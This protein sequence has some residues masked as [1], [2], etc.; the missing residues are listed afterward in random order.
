MAFCNRCGVEDGTSFW[1]GSRLVG[2]DGGL[3]VEAPLHEEAL[4]VGE[5]DPAVLR[6]R[7]QAF[8]AVRD[9]RPEVAFRGLERILRDRAAGGE[10][11]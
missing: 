10:A 7:R 6:R 5:L 9:E 1:G 11:P 8:S 4:L 2:P 3:I